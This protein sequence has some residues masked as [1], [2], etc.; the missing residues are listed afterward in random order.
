[1][2]LESMLGRLHAHL[3]SG[4]S[5]NARPYNS[6]Q[7]LD[8]MDLQQLGS[9]DPAQLITTLLEGKD[10][11]EIPAKIPVFVKPE[12]PEEQ[13]TEEQKAARN[14]YDRQAKVLNK[15][16]DI[17]EDAND[18][19]NDQGEHA[20]YIGF[21]LVSV[22]SRSDRGAATKRVLAPAILLPINMRVRRGAGAGVTLELS[23]DGADLVQ[24][25][26][27]LLAWLE[28]QTGANSDG[29]FADENGEEPW[30]E[31]A[32]VLGF[33]EK[34]AGIS[35]AGT[36]TA[37]SIV[38]RI[39]K[40]DALPNEPVI[41]P[42]AVLGLFPLTDPGLLRDTKWMIQ[43]EPELDGPVKA[44]LNAEAL[45]E[46][47]EA[48]LPKA[49]EHDHTSGSNGRP[50]K[51]YAQE[52]LVTHADPCQ[53][54][55][56]H[57]ARTSKALVV[58]GPPG[59]GKS[60]TIANI[61]GDH[62]A[63]GQRVLFV[64]DKRTA[65]DVVKY[66]LDS[67]GIGHLCGVVHD[68]QRDRKALYLGLRNRLEQL[69]EEPVMMDPAG[70]LALINDRLDLLHGELRGYFDILHA[71]SADSPSFHRLC[72]DWLE[73]QF[74]DVAPLPPIEGL[75]LEMIERHRT[76]IEEVTKRAI[77]ARWP[78]SPFQKVLSLSLMEYQAM[79]PGNLAMHLGNAVKKAAAIEAGRGTDELPV[80]EQVPLDQLAAARIELAKAMSEVVINAPL[81]LFSPLLDPATRATVASEIEKYRKD[82]GQLERPLDREISLH[83]GAALPTLAQCNQYLHR[84]QEWE[85]VSLNWHRWFA[86]KVKRE[87]KEAVGALGL[88]W[89]TEGVRQAKEFL[90]GVRVRHIWSDIYQRATGNPVAVEHSD[91]SLLRF[92]NGTPLICN[93]IDLLG[94]PIH[95]SIRESAVAS[96]KDKS[97][98][99]LFIA[100][101]RASADQ[102]ARLIEFQTS[103]EQLKLF[104]PSV[105]AAQITQLHS[106]SSTSA[107][108]EQCRE[109]L[110]MLEDTLR[111][112]DRISTLP[113]PLQATM[114]TV[115]ERGLSFEM[116]EPALRSA[117][118]QLAVNERLRTDPELSRIDS[119]RIE[120]GFSEMLSR[121]LEKTEQVRDKIKHAWQARA[122]E[123]LLASTGS[124]LNKQGAAL[125][126]RLFVRGHK[127]M[128]LRQMIASGSNTPNGDPLFDLCPVW[129]ASPS[130]VSQIFPKEALFDVIVFDE[131][132]Q[133]RL[134]EALP[135]LLRGKRVVIA[136]DPKQLPPTKFF[137]SALTESDDSDAESAEELFINR[138]SQAEDLLS[139]ALNLNV[140][141]A[142]LD[143]HY[144]SRNEALIGFS[145]D[146]FYEGR[147][148]PIPGHPG[149]KLMKTPIE[150]I[151]VDGTY[152]D[153]TNPEEAQAVVELVATLLALP[154]PPSIGVACFNITQRDAILDA[155]D[156]HAAESTEFAM[157]LEN[158]RQ[159]KG[160]DSFEG[161]FVKNLENVQGD[162]RDHMIICTTFGIDKEGKFRRNFGA[163]SRSGGER[164]LNVLVTRARDKVHVLT[165]IPRAEYISPA[166]LAEGQSWTGRHHLYAYLRYAELLAERFTN[167][168]E[169]V[170]ALYSG[171]MSDCEVLQT[172]TP[173]PVA[174]SVGQWLSNKHGIGNRVYWGNEG[175]CVDIALAHPGHPADV[176]IGVLTDFTRYRKTP[177]PILW[178]LFRST[179]L[180][181]QGWDL[182]RV[183]SPSVFKN[184]G[185]YLEEIRS[186]HQAVALTAQL[187]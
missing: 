40:T 176:T 167:W 41:V 92:A 154:N 73:L 182:L 161:L 173:S 64:C 118:L 105:V 17:A 127:A 133:C 123:K 10:S 183:W 141:E 179:V 129:M 164:R 100:R 160:R 162:E 44:F 102:C 169:R 47:E 178:E 107:W 165:S 65:L 35:N 57:H 115:A 90:S 8:V 87:A 119:E 56:V 71:E 144:R 149:N 39:P 156:K 45:A 3:T 113:A 139:S 7:R 51:T 4:P 108:L 83:L 186:R 29:L 128:K 80:Q 151:R 122:R 121:N 99:D 166:P 12:L 158:A 53:T 72:G 95:S 159:R 143:V 124:R 74:Q 9:L 146:A 48:H 153:R 84:I 31:I 13:W 67:M 75:T 137:E 76:D 25:N 126:Q 148:Q 185:K 93:L 77:K 175:F 88:G 36:F 55:A 30:K 27:G 140:Q 96:I 135:V 63:R 18:Y 86:G 33:I 26:L 163:L 16:R 52:L 106:G 157:R 37:Q 60:Q 98:L 61:I 147:L 120:S 54:E 177:D 168:Q 50:S 94:E 23:G 91:Q 117:A 136:G 181:A 70:N 109:Y 19:Y 150:L 58:H 42:G 171:S 1:M 97:T 11:L 2:I 114:N 110:P 111:M 34:N 24:P 103:M 14:R 49:V 69:A 172:A 79:E 155:M 152:I 46:P 101:L 6:R 174:E 85:S 28:Q 22:P 116:A 62:L 112:L 66:R 68:P 134:E 20:L 125:R 38:E 131:A 32:E 43:Q 82:I 89:D 180:L 104:T 145:N 170:N 78:E 132:S 138:Q 21:P 142:F 184:N 59:T 130:T 187:N 5:L 81:E 15:L